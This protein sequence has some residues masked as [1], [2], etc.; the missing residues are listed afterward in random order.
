ML[1][2]PTEWGIAANPA[3]QGKGCSSLFRSH[4]YSVQVQLKLEEKYLLLGKDSRDESR[5]TSAANNNFR[6]KNGGR[7]G[8]RERLLQGKVPRTDSDRL[9]WRFERVSMTSTDD[10]LKNHRA[11]HSWRHIREVQF[12]YFPGFFSPQVNAFIVELNWNVQVLAE[13]FLLEIIAKFSQPCLF[14]YTNY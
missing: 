6:S 4:S 10:T 9:A 11:H 8:E 3:R 14:F 1:S 12:W 13:G 5:L 2:L 7:E